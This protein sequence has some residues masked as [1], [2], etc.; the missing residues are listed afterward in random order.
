MSMGL[1]V[2]IIWLLNITEHHCVNTPNSNSLFTQLHKKSS[3]DIR[4]CFVI[5]V[6][7][8]GLE[9]GTSRL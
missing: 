7:Q 2:L 1:V 6:D 4:N 5:Y 8:L 3:C 9:P